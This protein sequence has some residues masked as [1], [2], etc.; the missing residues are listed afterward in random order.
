MCNRKTILIYC[1]WGNFGGA[2]RALVNL[3]KVISKKDFDITLMLLNK[4][5]CFLENIPNSVKIITP[6]FKKGMDASVGI[7][8]L[9]KNKLKQKNFFVA[10]NLFFADLFNRFF[11]WS[12]IL[13]K[14]LFEKQNIKY[15]CVFN[16]SNITGFG[17]II[18][19]NLYKF[20]KKYIWIHSNFIFGMVKNIKYKKI[21]GDYDYIFWV[22]KE[23]TSKAQK[24]YKSIAYKIFTLYNYIDVDS[25]LKLSNSTGFKDNYKGCKILSVG[26]LVYVKGFD[27]VMK[28]CKILLDKGYNIKWYVIGDGPEKEKLNSLIKENNL[29]NNFV[30]LGEKENPYPF[31]KEC[32]IYVQSSR[33]EGYCLTLSEAKIFNKP[34][35][36]TVFSGTYEQIKDNETGII[37]DTTPEGISAGVQ[38]LLDNKGLREKLSNNLKEENKKSK[39]DYFDELEKFL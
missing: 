36:T 28:A 39:T 15:D 10:V 25:I 34:I 26:R 11:G 24:A 12:S 14:L 17:P 38:K 35:V 18:S 32:D 31:F 9:I 6:P 21:F 5:F 37:V 1:C 29:D 8:N 20:Q 22:S 23:L 2:E 13:E 16:W 33:S 19:K 7:K 3:L 30:L 27:I 4:N